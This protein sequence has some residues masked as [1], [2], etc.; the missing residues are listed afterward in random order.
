MRVTLIE[1]S[2]ILGS[3]DKR[4]QKYAEKKIKARSRFN[5]MQ[6]TVTSQYLNKSLGGIYCCFILENTFFLQIIVVDPIF[7]FFSTL[8]N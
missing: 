3:F 5:L 7:Y 1:A 2:Q 6:T 8:F 4:L